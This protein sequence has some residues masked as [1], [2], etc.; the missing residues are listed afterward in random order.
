MVLSNS[1]MHSPGDLGVAGP[2]ESGSILSPNETPSKI[3]VEAAGLQNM[4]DLVKP[5]VKGNH[6]WARLY[7][8]I[9]AG[10]RVDMGGNASWFHDVQTLLRLARRALERDLA[11]PIDS[12]QLPLWSQLRRLID[13]R[14]RPV[15]GTSAIAR[16]N[17]SVRNDLGST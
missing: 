1:R 9:A 7:A 16:I 3:L 13:G 4:V 15:A 5:H 6:I 8:P 2:M 10:W 17:P 12:H 11:S 14:R